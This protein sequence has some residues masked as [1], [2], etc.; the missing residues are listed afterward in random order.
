MTDEFNWD[1]PPLSSDDVALIDAY[2][3]V[4]RSVDDLPFTQDFER[5][6]DELRGNHERETMRQV[7]LNLLRLRKQARLPRVLRATV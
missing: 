7:F 6:C 5:M 2:L 4:G 1:A 3:K